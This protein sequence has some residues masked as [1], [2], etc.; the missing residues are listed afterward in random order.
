MLAGLVVAGC[1]ST[2]RTG[3]AAPLTSPTTATT[4][5]TP[6][7]TA[8][9][10][11]STPVTASST[12]S[13]TQP[14]SAPPASASTPATHPSTHPAIRKVPPDAQY[15]AAGACPKQTAAQVRVQ[16]DPDVPVP[17]CVVVSAGQQLAVVNNTNEL[18]QA[19]SPI[20]I[21]WADYPARIVRAGAATSYARPFGSYLMP[22]VHRLHISL[23]QQSGAEIWLQG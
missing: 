11:V 19:G 12:A 7:M 10:P 23:Y 14:R 9:P 16:V 21:T 18:H 4:P 22:G 1:A 8:S 3:A 15:P 2:A 6:T 13:P 17:R 5:T 20:T